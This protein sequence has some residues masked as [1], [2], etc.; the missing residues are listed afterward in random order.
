MSE[1]YKIPALDTVAGDANFK[2]RISKIY[3]ICGFK[4]ILLLLA[5]VNN[6]LSSITLFIDSI[7]L[8]SKSPSKIIHFA[9]VSGYSD[10]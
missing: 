2:S 3:F 9:F 1:I 4:G 10:I 7:Q 5:K 8:V 6:L